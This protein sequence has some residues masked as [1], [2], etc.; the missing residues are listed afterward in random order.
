MAALMSALLAFCERGQFLPL[1]S[2]TLFM[3]CAITKYKVLPFLW[4]L[5][6][7]ASFPFLETKSMEDDI[8][9]EKSWSLKHYDL[10]TIIYAV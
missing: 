8:M 9:A 4:N 6:L 5:S 10:R 3:N 1:L 7:Y 2:S